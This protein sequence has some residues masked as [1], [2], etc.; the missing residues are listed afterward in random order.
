MIDQERPWIKPGASAILRNLKD[1][2]VGEDQ[3]RDIAL[4]GPVSL[5]VLQELTD[6]PELQADLA[7]LPRTEFLE[8]ELAGIPLVIARTG[9]TGENWGFEILVHPD[10]MEDLWTA[11]L[12]VGEK[13]GVKPAGLA[14]RDS[15]RIEAGLPLYG[16]ELAGPFGV[17]PIE[18]GFPGYVKYHKPF[19]VGRKP[20]LEMEKDR[21]RE[22]IRFR[23]DEKRS[24]RPHMADPVVDERGKE[25]GQVTSCSIDVN[26]YLVGLALVDR[27]YNEPGTSISI[28]PLRG[29]KLEEALLRGGRVTLPVEATVLSRFPGRDGDQPSWMGGED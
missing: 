6:D 22:I 14:C 20:L 29:E 1:P 28:F 11:I 4:Q 21:D 15:T 23:V 13:Y 12:E 3:K 26:G 19:F 27:R 9:Y 8:D 24:R 16:H 25:I 18:A 10:D 5:K 2:A 17:T 7:R